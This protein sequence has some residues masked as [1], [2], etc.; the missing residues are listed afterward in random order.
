MS[1]FDPRSDVERQVLGPS[2]GV[3]VHVQELRRRVEALER[4]PTIRQVAADPVADA[5]DGAAVVTATPRLWLRVGGVWR[6]TTL[7]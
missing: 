4:A 5:R 7:T 2:A 1:G 3:A 6:Y